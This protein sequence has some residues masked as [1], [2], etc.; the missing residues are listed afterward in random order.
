MEK[1]R[2]KTREREWERGRRERGT[3][4]TVYGL[5]K[6]LLHDKYIICS[7]HASCCSVGIFSMLLCGTNALLN[8]RMNALAHTPERRNL[9][10][11]CFHCDPLIG[12]WREIWFI[13][14]QCRAWSPLA[15][16]IIIIS[17]NHRINRYKYGW[18]A[19]MPL[20]RDKNTIKQTTAKHSYIE[21]NNKAICSYSF[22]LS[23][24][25]SS[26]FGAHKSQMKYIHV[27]LCLSVSLFSS[28]GIGRSLKTSQS[29]VCT[30]EGNNS[31][32]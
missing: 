23:S 2:S 27:A 13:P 25:S 19:F 26:C 28:R 10:I 17:L 20:T 24:S 22:P 12:K 8:I 9:S 18:R 21:S 3:S 15:I 29:S 14:M 5:E 4:R 31:S 30:D 6:Y 32:S 16:I 11:G 1:K 7:I